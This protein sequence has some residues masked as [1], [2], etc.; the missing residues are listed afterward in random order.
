MH[1][2][3]ASA[4]PNVWLQLLSSCV[5]ESYECPGCGWPLPVEGLVQQLVKHMDLV[6]HLQQQAAQQ[7]QQVS[8][9]Q[10]LIADLQRQLAE[11]QQQQEASAQQ[12]VLSDD[13]HKQLQELQL[14]QE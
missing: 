10:Q 14:T 2:L 7:Q 4:E 9:Q 3:Q 1:V 12:G 8:Q 11:Q 6:V 13:L 5:E